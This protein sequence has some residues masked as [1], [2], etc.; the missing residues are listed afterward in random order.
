MRFLRQFFLFIGLL[1]L[2]ASGIAAQQPDTTSQFVA[3]SPEALAR[4]VM[5]QF[6]SGSPEEFKRIYPF[7]DGRAFLEDVARRGWVRRSGLSRVVWSAPNRAVLLLS[8]YAV[9]GNSGDET[10]RSRTFSGFYEAT[11]SNGSWMLSRKLPIDAENR[12]HTHQLAVKVTPGEGLQVT[13][14]MEISVGGFYGFAVRLN[15]RARISTVQ[16]NGKA[17]EYAF[18]GGLLWMRVPGSATARLLLTYVLDVEHDPKANPNSGSFQSDYGHVRSQYIWH[19]LLDFNN[20]E[21][22]SIFDITVQVPTKFY[23]STS[24]P[25][26]DRIAGKIRVVRGQTKLPVN[27][28]TLAY[29]CGWQ[30]YV[31]RFG[32]VRL[33]AFVTPDFKPA[34]AEL[35][36]A[37]QKTYQLLL[38]RFGKPKSDYFAVAQARARRGSGWHFL[39]NNLIVTGVNGGVTSTPS[40][41]PAAM[42]G[43]ELSHTWTQPT[44][45]GGLFLMEGWA[46]FIESYLLTSEYGAAVGQAFWEA[47]RNWYETGGFDGQISIIGD[48]NNNGVAYSKGAW[49]L[50]LLRDVLGEDTFM[51][52]MRA[53][54][55]IRPGQPAGIKEF[56]LAMSQAARRDLW[57]LLKPWVE[58]KTIP[59]IQAHIEGQQA[60]FSQIGFVFELPLEVEFLTSTGSVRRTIQLK[61]RE[62]RLDIT[63]LGTVTNI[64][65]DPDHHLL[66]RRHRGEIVRFEVQAPEA[67]KVELGGDFASDSIPATAKDGKWQI[68]LPLTEGRYNWYW[69]IDG[70]RQ[71]VEAGGKPQS[72]MRQVRPVQNLNSAYP[73]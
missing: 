5:K 37:F 54:I 69:L 60:I 35:E 62:T 57:A 30:P 56:V 31:L 17:V 42:L 25:Q 70:K 6:A 13:D 65:I 16:L 64:Y 49:I 44:G 11:K 18:D 12:I 61:Q 34:R 10:T 28:A 1:T 45:P 48:L 33:E 38:S 71:T 51:R 2:M 47:H 9:F 67:K 50:R 36:T 21:A 20:I 46:T 8:G 23:L 22:R 41:F 40:P 19:P 27:T 68:E 52:G 26:T 63:D 7:D 72:E 53:Y 14:T 43:H 24:L 39:S 73:R 4:L 29:D 59:N 3:S 15:H 55:Q 66:L 32:E 58:E